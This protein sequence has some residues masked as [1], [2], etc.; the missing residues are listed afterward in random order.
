MN[1][2]RAPAPSHH[3]DSPSNSSPKPKKRKAISL[4]CAFVGVG[5]LDRD[6]LAQLCAIDVLTGEVL[7]DVLVT[8]DEPLTHYRTKYGGITDLTYHAYREHGLVLGSVEDA[9]RALFE[10]MDS[11]TLLVGFALHNDLFKLGISHSRI[12]DTQ[13]VTREAVESRYGRELKRRWGLRDLCWTFL[14]KEVQVNDSGHDCLEDA[15]APRE[16]VYWLLDQRNQGVYQ[17][18]VDKEV[19]DKIDYWDANILNLLEW[20]GSASL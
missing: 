14:S 3:Q 18:G 15:F 13:V 5:P 11:E 4:D 12:I 8:P 19:R 9:R 6:A 1:L 17:T 7:L 20:E 2:T 10:V 16:L